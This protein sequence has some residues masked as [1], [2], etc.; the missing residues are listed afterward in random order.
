MK[1]IQLVGL[2]IVAAFALSALVGA[3]S[4]AAATPEFGQCKALSKNTTP[5]DKK[6]VY[7]DA[8]CTSKFE[9]KGKPTPKGHYEWYPGPASS[10]FSLK[11]GEYTNSGCTT[12]SAKPKKGSFEKEDGCFP[13]CAG[14]TAGGPAAFLEG[15]SKLKIECKTNG[16][17]GG[18]IVSAT[19]G[20]GIAVYTGCHI[21]ALGGVKCK[22][23]GAKAEEIKTYVLESTPE[24]KGGKVWLNYT[25]V[26]GANA[27]YLAEFNCEVVGIRVKG[28][29]AGEASGGINEMGV[30]QTQTFGKVVDGIEGQE[31]TSESNT[32]KGFEKPEK[33]WQF[34]TTEFVTNDSN[35][36]EI[37]H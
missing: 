34:Q 28:H 37:K 7:K 15:E 21:E 12:K 16:S 5:K 31:L 20:T 14:I 3:A 26:A 6:G 36:T 8:G 4:A 25:N 10:C 9:K 23:A 35:G 11:K 27:P 2:C 24:E 1:R 18:S 29:A 19:K 33:S 22:S 30:K 13:N 17:E 32:G